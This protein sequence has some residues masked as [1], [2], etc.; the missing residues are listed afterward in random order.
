MADR[1]MRTREPGGKPIIRM[2][3][4]RYGAGVAVLTVAAAPADVPV[5]AAAPGAGAVGPGMG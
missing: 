1:S 5:L 3:G 2:S 4:G